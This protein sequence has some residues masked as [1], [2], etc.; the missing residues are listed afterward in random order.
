MGMCV[1]ALGVSAAYGKDPLQTIRK[2]CSCAL[3]RT[4]SA[5]PQRRSRS[6]HTAAPCLPHQ[7]PSSRLPC[8]TLR[9]LG[10]GSMQVQIQGVLRAAPHRDPCGSPGGSLAVAGSP[11]SGAWLH[12]PKPYQ[13]CPLA[14]HP[15]LQHS[16]LCRP[17]STAPGSPGMDLV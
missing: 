7:R 13:H 5:G 10:R 1:G 3:K 2:L 12:Y 4:A 16:P 11:R 14:S 9:N 8:L 6:S 15:G 17:A